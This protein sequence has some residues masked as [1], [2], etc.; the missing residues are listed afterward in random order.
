[1]QGNFCQ[2]CREFDIQHSDTPRADL[3]W[4]VAQRQP[5]D[6]ARAEK[7][8]R[9][10]DASWLARRRRRHAR[11]FDGLAETESTVGC[12]WI[13]ALPGPPAGR[14]CSL[15][16]VSSR[17]AACRS[18]VR[19]QLSCCALTCMHVHVNVRNRMH[20]V[21]NRPA[22]CA[23]SNRPGDD[24]GALR[25]ALE[26]ERQRSRCDSV[27]SCTSLQNTT[28]CVGV[29]KRLCTVMRLQ[30]TWRSGALVRMTPCVFTRRQH[31]CAH[32]R[33]HAHAATC[34]SS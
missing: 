6:A 20:F 5:D 31:V 14:L 17:A 24:A 21:L 28:A 25:K 18:C 15:T 30:P 7:H 27:C 1:M 10:V 3:P 13:A 33:S 16:V 22:A 26:A 2:A 34:I 11:P 32:V 8:V 19:A 9:V 29:H 12:S 4:H 23:D